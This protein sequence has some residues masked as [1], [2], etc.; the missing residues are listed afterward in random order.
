M[1]RSNTDITIGTLFIALLLAIGAWF[2]IFSP[3]LDARAFAIEQTSATNDQN[4]LLQT[5]LDGLLADYARLDE[6]NAD[7]AAVRVDLPV[8]EDLESVRSTINDTANAYGI[9]VVDLSASAPAVVD[10]SHL[11]LA[12]AA[13]AVGKESVVDGL[14]FTSLVATPMQLTVEGDYAKVLGAL[15]DLQLGDH[16][17]VYV[18]TSQITETEVGSGVYDGVFGLDVFTYVTADVDPTL[19]ESLV[20]S[21][22]TPSSANPFTGT[23]GTE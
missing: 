1:R 10:P 5:Q 17:F 9:T 6:I 12:D 15:T 4:E 7:L 8:R 19:P 22:E 21:T 11:V 2:L 20:D 3:A 14:T 18:A 23:A 13:A 16:R